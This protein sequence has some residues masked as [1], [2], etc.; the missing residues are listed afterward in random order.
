MKTGCIIQARMTSTRLPGKVL[1]YLDT[2]QHVN[3]L[4]HIIDR[5]KQSKKINEI[6]IATTI[7]SADDDI[8]LL[9]SENHIGIYRGSENDVLDRYFNAATKYNLDNIIRITSDC[10]FIDSQVLDD[11][12][13]QYN[14]DDYDYASNCITRTY[15]HGLDCEIFSYSALT[16]AHKAA[17]ETK[18][19]EHVTSYIYNHPEIFKLGNLRL[20]R[21]DYSQIRI[22]VDTKLD[23]ALACIIYNMLMK[24]SKFPSFR[25]IAELFSEHPYLKL[26]N[27]DVIQKRSFTSVEE[28]VSESIRILKLQELYNAAQILG[29]WV[30]K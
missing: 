7:N 12:I 13:D 15:P 16:Y 26:I 24:E 29:E 21:E 30:K 14:S 25:R 18:E 1:K 9:A 27:E 20:E 11:L 4:Q 5:V 22:T 6:I 28:E 10:P 8:V 2:E 17:R 3:I 23:Y 19:R